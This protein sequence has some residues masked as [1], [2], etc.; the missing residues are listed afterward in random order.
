MRR[1]QLDAVVDAGGL[2]G[3][4]G[5]RGDRRALVDQDRDDVGQVL[6]ALRVVARE[7]TDRAAQ[8]LVVEGIDAGGDL[9]HGE[10]VRCRV[11]VLDH[12]RHRTVRGTDD[13]AVP[14][15][16][17][18]DAGQHRRGPGAVLVHQRLQRVRR[19]QRGV[20]GHHDDRAV[21]GG[22]NRLER[23]PNGVTGAV[24]LGLQ[25][26]DGLGRDLRE[27]VADLVG[28]VAD[29]DDGVGRVQWR[30]GG[31]HMP[32]HRASGEAVQHLG[33]RRGL[34]PGALTGGQHDHGKRGHGVPFDRRTV[35]RDW[36]SNPDCT[37]PKAGGLPIT[38]SRNRGCQPTGVPAAAEPRWL[39]TVA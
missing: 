9:G 35:L 6:F 19:Q 20:A 1:G 29:H 7:R 10:L 11:L 39:A 36:D 31:E 15:R 25:D 23:E 22:G 28:A 4:H 38:P 16:V 37:A 12:P 27:V 32:E 3:G 5:D 8:L 17:V 2:V 24:L 14:G 13:P 26:G 33:Q 34:H 21:R 30:G 18:D